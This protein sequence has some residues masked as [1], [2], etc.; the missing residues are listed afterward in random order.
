MTNV[1]MDRANPTNIEHSNS[2]NR[3]VCLIIWCSSTFSGNSS[4]SNPWF[5][6][7]WYFFTKVWQ[8]S[9]EFPSQLNCELHNPLGAPWSL[10]FCANKSSMSTTVVAVDF[11][12]Q[13]SSLLEHFDSSSSL[14]DVRRT[15]LFIEKFKSLTLRLFDWTRFEVDS[16]KAVLDSVSTLTSL[17]RLRYFSNRFLYLWCNTKH[18]LVTEIIFISLVSSHSLLMFYQL[19]NETHH[20]KEYGNGCLCVAILKVRISFFIGRNVCLVQ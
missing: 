4:G 17:D 14:D 13:H 3:T 16:E 18:P 9:R 19:T 12:V 6:S 5:V 20:Q 15:R 2:I 1:H 11:L 7:F 10:H 8:F